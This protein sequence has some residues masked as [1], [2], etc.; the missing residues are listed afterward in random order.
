MHPLFP[1]YISVF[2]LKSLSKMKFAAV[3]FVDVGL[4]VPGSAMTSQTND[5]IVMVLISNGC[6]SR[7]KQ[8]TEDMTRPRKRKM[9]ALIGGDNCK[10]HESCS[11]AKQSKPTSPK[12]VQNVCVQSD[13][14]S[15]DST[16]TDLGHQHVTI[17]RNLDHDDNLAIVHLQSCDLGDVWTQQ[18]PIPLSRYPEHDI[19]TGNLTRA[20]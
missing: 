4:K 18:Y 19:K 14:A 16:S 2:T 9:E 1:T 20:V 10:A 11:S 5:V 3:F 12:S 13:A 17:L 15:G 8:I 6:R 7:S